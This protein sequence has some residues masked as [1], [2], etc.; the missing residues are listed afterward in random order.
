MKNC[1]S[2]PKL[3]GKVDFKVGSMHSNIK[4]KEY[5]KDMLFVRRITEKRKHDAGVLSFKKAF[6]GI[7]YWFLIMLIIWFL[8]III[9]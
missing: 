6:Y 9:N 7:A 4:L 2:N 1:Y 5:Q 3:T 8:T